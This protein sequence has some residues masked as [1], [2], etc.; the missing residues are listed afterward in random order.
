MPLPPLPAIFQALAQMRLLL[1]KCPQFRLY[2]HQDS[3]IL[4][5]HTAPQ[6]RGCW[7]TLGSK[8]ELKSVFVYPI[9]SSNVI[10]RFEPVPLAYSLKDASFASMR[11][12]M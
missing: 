10:I 8:C 1:S 11:L 6:A 3:F 9:G 2:Y 7:L 4:P 5:L 12:L